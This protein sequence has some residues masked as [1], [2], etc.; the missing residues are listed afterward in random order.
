MASPASD[1]QVDLTFDDNSGNESGFEVERSLDGASF[2]LVASLGANTTSFSDTGLAADTGRFA[3]AI[4]LT[5][6]SP[7]G[8]LSIC[9]AGH[10]LPLIYRAEAQTWSTIDQPEDAAGIAN[11]PL[12]VIEESGYVGRELTLSPGDRFVAFSDGMAEAVS[13]DGEMIEADGLARLFA[14]AT[15]GSAQE[16]LDAVV[17]EVDA[18]A[19]AWG[20]GDD[21]SSILV[22]MP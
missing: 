6:F 8:R 4:V 11:L 10:P 18:F 14:N 2:S 21:L 9:N 19:G 5:F 22:M 17:A 13:P 16:I 3:T 7:K 15:G 1:S 12:G 20:C